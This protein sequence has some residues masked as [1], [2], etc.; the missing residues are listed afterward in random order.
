M[1]GL[2]VRKRRRTSGENPPPD[3]K[4]R[5]AAWSL[6]RITPTCQAQSKLPKSDRVSRNFY[7]S[8]PPSRKATLKAFASEREAGSSLPGTKWL[9]HNQQHSRCVS[10]PRLRNNCGI[11]EMQKVR[12]YG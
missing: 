5:F 8:F 3:F 10:L 6:Q 7:R 2:R 4:I 11:N 1:L 12:V 9:G